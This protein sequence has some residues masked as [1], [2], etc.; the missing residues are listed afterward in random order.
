M[1]N[2]PN[3]ADLS[4][5]NRPTKLAERF[6]EL[7]DNEWTDCFEVLGKRPGSTEKDTIQILLNVCLVIGNSYQLLCL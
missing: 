5:M 6:S 3:I 2:N 4:D 7:Y 1:D